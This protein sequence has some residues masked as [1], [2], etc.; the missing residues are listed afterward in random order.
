MDC[1]WTDT[2]CFK[3]TVITFI[4]ISIENVNLDERIWGVSDIKRY[5]KQKN[6]AYASKK[7][8]VLNI[9]N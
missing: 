2:I 4:K 9:L 1:G 8:R 7:R 3:S 5:K 6:K